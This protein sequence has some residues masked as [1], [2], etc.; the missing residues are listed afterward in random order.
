MLCQE[1]VYDVELDVCQDDSTHLVMSAARWPAE[2]ITMV[3]GLP[4]FVDDVDRFAL[5]GFIEL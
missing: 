5:P 1:D 4:S 2:A 3:C